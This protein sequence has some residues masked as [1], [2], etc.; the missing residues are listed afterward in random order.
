ME[1]ILEYIISKEQESETILSFLRSRGFSRHILH[2]MK[3][4]PGNI[5]WNGERGFGKTRLSAGDRLRI[6]VPETETCSAIPRELPFEILYEDQDLLGISK[7]PGMPVHPSIGNYEN[8]LSNGVAYYEA[9]KGESYPI[10]CINRLDRDTTGVLLIAKNP[11]SGAILS[12]DIRDRKIHR[13]Y[14]ALVE[15]KTPPEGTIHEPVGRVSDSVILRQVDYE[16]GETAVTHYERLEYHN[17]LSLLKVWLETGR[18]HQIRV[19]MKHIG[20]PLPGD[21]LY[22]PVYDRIGRQP[23]HSWKLS[24]THPVTKEEMELTAP[25]PEDMKKAFGVD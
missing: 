11:L 20:H 4:N 2:A 16:N 7:P 10:R 6:V 24:F 25:M 8:T 21:Y 17:G 19:H 15:G 9:S 23:L 1:R 3:G 12:S 18:T 5:E 13:T 22:H 14:L